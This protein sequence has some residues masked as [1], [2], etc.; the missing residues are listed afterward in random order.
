MS[1]IRKPTLIES[2]ACGGVSACFAVNFTHPIELVKT[3]MQ[4]TGGSIGATCGGVMANEG[5][6]AFWKGLPFAWGRELSYTSVKLGAY[7]PVRN[8]IGAGSPDAPFYLK[9][10]A[11]AI[12]GGVGSFIGNPFDVLKTL[13]Q[14][15]TQKDS[16]LGSLVGNMY[17]DQGI[18]GFYRGVEVNIMRACVLNATKM[19]VYD[20]TKGYVTDYTGWNRKDVKTSFS[21]AFVAGFFMTVTVAPWDMLRTK[22]MNQ[23]TDKKIY[24]GFRDCLVKTVK[25][26]GV[27]SLWRGFI[28]IWARFA[29]QA[30]LQL[31]G[32]EVIY[33][34]MGFK[35]I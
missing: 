10:L 27:I 34:F 33:N 4:V 11:G 3:R 5:A 35:G 8:A 22:L 12:T 25:A 18:A 13:A 9:F 1:E 31:I 24:D 29:P 23:P 14:T 15:N 19:G 26:D 6:L 32:I 7:A 16:G 20:I 28:P 21:S 2:M 30:T 17:R